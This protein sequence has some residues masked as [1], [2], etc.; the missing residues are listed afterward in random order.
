MNGLL[1]VVVAAAFMNECQANKISF[2]VPTNVT[3]EDN[4]LTYL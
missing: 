1:S 4:I 3:C 2:V